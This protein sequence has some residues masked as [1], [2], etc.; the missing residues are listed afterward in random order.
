MSEINVAARAASAPGT[1]PALY[2][3]LDEVLSTSK[4]RNSGGSKIRPN[5]GYTIVA[6]NIAKLQG[7][8][9]PLQ[10]ATVLRILRD[11]LTAKGARTVK[12]EGKDVPVVSETDLHKM[13]EAAVKSG[14]LKT[15][16]E[17]FHI[18][19]YY[20]TD[21]VKQGVLRQ[22]ELPLAS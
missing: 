18:F 11:G 21:L 17:P 19:R 8:N 15:K 12:I 3:N 14:A 13:I 5:V 22:V 16:Q 7:K 2:A 4:S 9:V 20:R 1:S 6:E 10:E